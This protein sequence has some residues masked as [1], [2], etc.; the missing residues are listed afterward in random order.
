MGRNKCVMGV[1]FFPARHAFSF[2]TFIRTAGV[3]FFLPVFILVAGCA[4]VG[5]APVTRDTENDHIIKDVPFYPQEENQ[6]GPAS[7]A[8]VL[9]YWGILV[10][11]K[12]VAKEIYS[13]SARGT[14]SI[15]MVLYAKSK[16]L[17]ASWYSG[18]PDDLRKEIDAGL[19]VIVLV[20]KGF[21]LLQVNHFMVVVGYSGKGVIV[22]SGS[23]EKR[24]VPMSDFLRSW[25]RTEYWTLLIKK[26]KSDKQRVTS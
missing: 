14:L 2:P 25:E 9:N 16:G 1:R 26:V 13:R 20:D 5:E 12:D 10:T 17:E 23:D 8:G 4:S 21:S 22:N 19:P 24:F 7:L 18:G 15:D 6:C 11:P 3:C